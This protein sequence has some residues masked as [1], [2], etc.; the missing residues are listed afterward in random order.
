MYIY[1]LGSFSLLLGFFREFYLLK[2][3]ASQHRV[4]RLVVKFEMIGRLFD[5]RL[6]QL[7]PISKFLHLWLGPVSSFHRFS[8]FFGLG[9]F[10]V[11]AYGIVVT[12]CTI[13]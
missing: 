1:K 4:K 12:H 10:S 6:V 5:G 3:A 11:F 13:Q 2:A 7:A 8:L 9:R